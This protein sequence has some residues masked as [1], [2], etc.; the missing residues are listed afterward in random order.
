MPY[1]LRLTQLYCLKQWPCMPQARQNHRQYRHRQSETYPLDG[2]TC[3]QRY[4]NLGI[5]RMPELLWHKYY[6]YQ[7]Q[8]QVHQTLSSGQVKNKKE[9]L[10]SFLHRQELGMDN[11]N[12]QS[13][14]SL[15]E[16][17]DYRERPSQ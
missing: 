3:S 8:G 7:Q 6:H 15:I 14:Q 12:N 5:A 2:H 4:K 11:E 1:N 10:C 13:Q 17:P 9:L 16:H